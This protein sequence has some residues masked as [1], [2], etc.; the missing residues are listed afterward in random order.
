[1]TDQSFQ[2]ASVSTRLEKRDGVVGLL[3]DVLELST[4][5]QMTLWVPDLDD[6]IDATALLVHN[7]PMLVSSALELLDEEDFD[8]QQ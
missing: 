5:A 8:E 1:M 7:A 3:L 2:M 4:G 6:G